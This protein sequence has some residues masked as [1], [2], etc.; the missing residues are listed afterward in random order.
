ME[1]K[2]LKIKAVF[3][4]K[5]NCLLPKKCA[6]EKVVELENSV[7]RTFSN[8]TLAYYDFIK[9]NSEIS[10]KNE[11]GEQRVFLVMPKNGDDGIIINT[12][13]Y[14]YAKYT[15]Y[16]PNARQLLNAPEQKQTQ[17]SSSNMTLKDLMNLRLEDVHLCHCDEDIELATIVELDADTL[18]AKGKADWADILDAKVEKIYEGAYGTQIELSGADPERLTDFSYMLA[19][20]CPESKY[21]EWV[22][23]SSSQSAEQSLQ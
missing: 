10:G 8:D 14:E 4:C 17:E 15:S 23:D 20:Q 5:H 9:E 12:E 2:N 3:N 18:T 22:Y 6:I 13:G 7:F 21:D 19:G 11:N 1:N 16:M